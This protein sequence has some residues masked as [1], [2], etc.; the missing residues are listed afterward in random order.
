MKELKGWSERVT[1]AYEKM[2]SE[3]KLENRTD[4]M[5]QQLA[6]VREDNI[7][8]FGTSIM[9][10]SDARS[11][12]DTAGKFLEGG[13]KNDAEMALKAAI[14]DLNEAIQEVVNK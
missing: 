2:I 13:S 8:K 5:K 7:L 4:P 6:K 12:I 10:L 9:K 1:D 11:K 3:G 14:V